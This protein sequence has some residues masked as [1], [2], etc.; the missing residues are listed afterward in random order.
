MYHGAGL[1]LAGA[2]PD[3]AGAETRRSLGHHLLL[4]QILRR[5]A[6]FCRTDCTR[7][8]KFLTHALNKVQANLDFKKNYFQ[9]LQY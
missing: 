6:L 9:S 1:S 5:R 8:S 3:V 7:R 2:R 4:P